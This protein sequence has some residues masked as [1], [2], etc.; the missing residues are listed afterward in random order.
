MKAHF[1][2]KIAFETDDAELEKRIVNSF[3]GD[4][5]WEE[6]LYLL[7]FVDNRQ[8]ECRHRRRHENKKHSERPSKRMLRRTGIH[9]K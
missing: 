8:H 1:E 4:I 6:L 7:E 9:E 2:L 3:D 5:D